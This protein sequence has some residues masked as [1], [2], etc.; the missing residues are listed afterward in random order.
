MGYIVEAVSMTEHEKVQLADFPRAPVPVSIA[1]PASGP[2]YWHAAWSTRHTVAAV[3]AGGA[4][5]ALLLSAMPGAGALGVVVL[6]VAALI[7]GITIATYVPPVG[8]PAKEHLA[9]GSCA[10]LPLAI[11]FIAPFMLSGAG[12]TA[13]MAVAVAVFYAGAAG[14]RIMDHASC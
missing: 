4:L 7:G 9:G 10:A 1:A 3:V 12:P 13:L 8:V 11:V 14:K 2:A 5:F 6:G